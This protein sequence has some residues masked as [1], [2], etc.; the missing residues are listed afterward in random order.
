MINKNKLNIFYLEKFLIPYGEWVAHKDKLPENIWNMI[1]NHAND[2]RMYGP[3]CVEPIGLGFVPEL[4]HFLLGSGQGPG[5]LWMENQQPVD[6]PYPYDGRPIDYGEI[7][8][9]K[10]F[11]TE[12]EAESFL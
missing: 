5:V 1:A 10:P 2:M 3:G 12:G 8:L 7:K 9:D 6:G 4:G 11:L